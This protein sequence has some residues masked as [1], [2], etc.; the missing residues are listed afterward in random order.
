MELISE[1][2]MNQLSVYCIVTEV[3]FV[4]I[5]FIRCTIAI[6]MGRLEETK[7]DSIFEQLKGWG[8]VYLNFQN[9]IFF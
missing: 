1:T 8:I 4:C 5:G 6:N 2:F 7:S 3:H 9:C